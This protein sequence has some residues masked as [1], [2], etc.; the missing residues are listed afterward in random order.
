MDE[1]AKTDEKVLK[2]R[3]E[4]RMT[5]AALAHF[6]ATQRASTQERIITS[7]MIVLKQP[8]ITYRTARAAL[9]NAVVLAKD[10]A[11]Y[12]KLA[13]ARM[14]VEPTNNERVKK[15]NAVN[16]EALDHFAATVQSLKKKGL[17]F[18]PPGKIGYP[19]GIEGV[20]VSCFP[21]ALIG[22]ENRD[23]THSTGAL[24]AV[25]RKGKHNARVCEV[26]AQIVRRA[27]AKNGYK[28][29]E[30]EL[31]IVVDVFN[32]AKVTA[33]KSHRQIDKEIDASCRFIAALWP[34]I[35]A[36][37]AET[38]MGTPVVREI[39]LRSPEKPQIPRSAS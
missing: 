32:E 4:P 30:S 14:R 5:V 29:V 33:P 36:K 9:R 38:E 11:N 7:E 10:P 15:T 3:K 18:G 21:V 28:S 31:C 16:S 27:L 37:A 6:V 26:A 2:V 35:Y 34:K 23:G 24:F 13:A 8:V 19:V 20:A 17:R 22:R 1:K 12:L 39:P 25:V